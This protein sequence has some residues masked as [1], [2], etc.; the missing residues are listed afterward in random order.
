M[1]SVVY[2]VTHLMKKEYQSYTNDFILVLLFRA[3]PTAY[4]N[5]R[6]GVKPELCWP[7]PQQ[8]GIQDASATYTTAHG[9]AGSLTHF[10]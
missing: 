8:H 7:T 5:S 1:A 4:G 10:E 6:L 3:A 2:S 9:N